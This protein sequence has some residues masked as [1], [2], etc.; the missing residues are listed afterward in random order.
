[1]S[2]DALCKSLLARF[3]ATRVRELS[4]IAARNAAAAAEAEG[5]M[6]PGVSTEMLASSS[7]GHQGGN[8]LAMV[9]SL[10]GATKE[11]KKG[12]AQPG[13]KQHKPP[14][15][16]P[17]SSPPLGP[18]QSRKLSIENSPPNVEYYSCVVPDD[19]L[20]EIVAEKLQVS[21]LE[22]FTCLMKR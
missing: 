14:H 9:A 10:S 16:S 17:P 12:A 8:A 4:I 1:M 22:H 20:V 3:S 5:A 18:P 7:V 13:M 11:S 19:L 2:S 6:Q 15:M 21:N